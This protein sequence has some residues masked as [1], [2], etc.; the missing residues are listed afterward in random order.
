M[1][2]ALTILCY[3]LLAVT[4]LVLAQSARQADNWHFGSGIS[5]SF[6]AGQPTLTPPS[7][8][9]TFEGASSLSDTMGNL[10]FYSNGG[11][12]PPG[13]GGPDG[14]DQDYGTIWN[15]NHEVMYDM[16]GEEGGGFSARQSALAMPAPGNN[17]DLYYLFT[18]EETE[19]DIGGS[20]PG[21]PEGRGL[22]YFTIDM[23]L[24]GGLGGVVLADQRVQ[25]P[26]Y[27]GL[28]ATP[29]AGGEGYWVACHNSVDGTGGRLFI[30]PVTESGVGTP[31]AFSPENGVSGRIKFSPDGTM[32]YL[33]GTV[34][35]FNNVSGEVGNSMA[36]FTALSDNNATF[37]PDSR[38]IYGIQPVGVLSNVVVRHDLVT[39]EILPVEPLEIPGSGDAV[40][41]NGAFQIGPNGNIYFLEQTFAADGNIAYGLSEIRCVS[42]SVPT[43]VRN[44]LDLSAFAEQ[45]AFG[46]NPPQF[47]DAIF[48]TPYRPD[49]TSLETEEILICPNDNNQLTARQEGV[50]YLWSTGDTTQTI[51]VPAPGNY[52]V[53]ISEECTTTID[54]REVMIQDATND[55]QVLGSIYEDCQLQCIVSLNT[56]VDFDSIRVQVGFN[57]PNGEVAPIFDGLF[58]EDRLTYP[59]LPTLGPDQVGYIWAFVYSACGVQRINLIDLPEEGPPPFE[60]RVSLPEA[61]LPCVGEDLELAVVTDGEVAIE[62][63]LWE[64]GS[65]DN[66]RMITAE[67][68]AI[69]EVMAISVCGDTTDIEVAPEVEE[70]CDCRDDLADVITPNGDGTNDSFKLFTNCPVTD[71]TLLIFNRW[72]QVVF[73]SSDPEQAWDGTRNGVPQNMDMYVYRMVF[74]YPEQTEVQKREGSFSLIR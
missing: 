44:L 36:T 64:D 72:G 61:N 12:R 30:T 13:N 5:I 40:L 20:V 63:V 51:T 58:L 69:Y 21:Q 43:V 53:T 39:G 32:V 19:F 28:D 3:S 45:S 74:R 7:S 67:L 55:P 35:A 10:L 62:S 23:N 68:D 65:T 14:T 34:Y 6:V 54:C 56:A 4:Q 70:F 48:S 17:P 31:V 47:V 50:S 18:M 60:V 11:G 16:R 71:Y 37:T 52:C 2:F 33:Q 57:I 42:S 25:V 15:R 66:P 46:N 8:M 41:V 73:E 24:N 29:M 1:R 49:T 9:I 22:S 27:E 59:K 38:F 26:A